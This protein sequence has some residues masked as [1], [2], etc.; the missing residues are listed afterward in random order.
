MQI[1]PY[2]R[3]WGNSN[4]RIRGERVSGICDDIYDRITLIY[5]S[6]F[7]TEVLKPSASTHPLSLSPTP[8]HRS[9]PRSSA[10]KARSAL[11]LR[12]PKGRGRG[13]VFVWCGGEVQTAL[14]PPV[15][16]SSSLVCLY[17]CPRVLLPLCLPL[18]GTVPLS[19]FLSLCLY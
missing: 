7:I 2:S 18:F 1:T 10:S 5:S 14:S 15:F 11:C 8:S 17:S 19:L 9:L 13:V 16:S 12:V 3:G 6:R 4:P